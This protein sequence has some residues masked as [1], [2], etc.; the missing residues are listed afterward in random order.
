MD[1]EDEVVPGIE[2]QPETK[3][4]RT[5]KS[6]RKLMLTSDEIEP[7]YQEHLRRINKGGK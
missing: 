3:S 1:K 2:A 5:T 4:K 6:K 7:R